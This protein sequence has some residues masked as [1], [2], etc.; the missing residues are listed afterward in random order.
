MATLKSREERFGKA[1][2]LKLLWK[3]I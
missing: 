3:R 1:Y 2:Q